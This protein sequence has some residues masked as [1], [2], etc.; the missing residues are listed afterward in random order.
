MNYS[1][2]IWD[3]NGTILDDTDASIKSENV[4]LSRRNMPLIESR[5]HYHSLF[6]FPVKE[7]YKKLGHN[8]KLES[9]DK[10]SVEWVEQYLEHSKTACLHDGVLDMLD[11]IKH[12][13][14]PQI[15]LSATEISMLRSQVEALGITNY[16]SE[17]LALDNIHAQSKTAIALEWVSR[18]KPEKA[19]L[20]GDTV[21]DYEVAH[22]MGIDCV[23]I[24]NGHQGKSS[25]KSLGVPVYDTMRELLASKLI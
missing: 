21:H 8:F 11:K 5:E 16:F 17:L 18:T 14:I 3:F 25:L 9:Y 22:E 19:V 4:L 15:I 12:A 13:G 20:I 10:L 24:A 23:L 2:V 1:H 7:Y 6:C